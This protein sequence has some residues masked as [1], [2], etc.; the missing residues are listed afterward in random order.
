MLDESIAKLVNFGT[1]LT[2]DESHQ[3]FTEI[4][5]EE[6]DTDKI[7]GLIL[8]LKEKGYESAE[9]AGCSKAF[10]QAMKPIKSLRTGI[11]GIS[12]LALEAASSFNV[13]IAT[14][15]VVAGCGIP[16]T[17][18]FLNPFHRKSKDVETLAALGIN[19]KLTAEQIERCMNDIGIS[20]VDIKAFFEM[21]ENLENTLFSLKT[22]TIFDIISVITSPLP[23][24]YFLIG[25]TDSEHSET[26]ADA[27][28]ILDAQRAMIVRGEDN[29]DAI[30]LCESTKISETNKG[31]NS[32]YF[33]SSQDFGM[34]PVNRSEL[35]GG[36][37]EQNAQTI[38]K[39]LEGENSAKADLVII[40]AAAALFICG[41]A[42]SWEDGVKK[43]RQ[44]LKHGRALSKFKN[45]QNWTQNCS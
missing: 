1:S 19:L 44:S 4:L 39:I 5:K 29:C 15:F 26:I 31:Q 9:I 41:I 18:N 43:A 35:S 14:C 40:N 2:F 34:H 8:N 25:T 23:T 7:A 13:D 6:T 45:V 11:I 33:I 16:V 30:S 21:H 22:E 24:K 36:T 10:A 32:T 12:T 37:A 28:K 17:K 3:A 38:I 27:L 42:K 20:F